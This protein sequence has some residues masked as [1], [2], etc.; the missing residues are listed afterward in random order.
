[1]PSA[2]SSD[3]TTLA[4]IFHSLASTPDENGQLPLSTYPPPTFL[5][6]PAGKMKEDAIRALASLFQ[7]RSCARWSNMPSIQWWLAR[8]AKFQATDASA[9][10]SASPH[11][12]YEPQSHEDPP[13]RVGCT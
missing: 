12:T 1:M 6:R 13:T 11:T 2:S 10:P 9:C 5:A 7:T 3:E 8:L 4:S